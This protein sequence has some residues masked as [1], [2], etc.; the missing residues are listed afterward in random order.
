R[1]HRRAGG[2]CHDRRV[3]RDARALP[4]RRHQGHRPVPQDRRVGHARHRRVLR[5]LLADPTVRRARV[6]QL[7]VQP[8]PPRHRV[9]RARRRA[10]GVQP[11]TRLRLHRA[12]RRAAARQELRVVRGVRSAGHDRVAVPRDAA[13]ARQAARA[14]TASPAAASSTQEAVLVGLA[15]A[16]LG[17]LAGSVVGLAMPAALV[18]AANGAISGSRR[19]YDWSSIKGVG[20]F[21]LDSTWSLANTAAGLAAHA[22]GAVRGEPGYVPALSER[23]N[24]HVYRRGFQPRK[25]FAITLGNVISGAGDVGKPRRVKLVTDHEDVHVWQARA[26]GPLYPMLYVGW[27]AGG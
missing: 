25:G 1:R 9:Q 5:R 21:A 17:A 19:V 24:R 12:R 20:A 13:P 7:P 4:H 11:G 3:R 16:G 26:L 23:L 10:G 14:V 22:L 18:G 6:D 8:E 27:M 2:G 15:G